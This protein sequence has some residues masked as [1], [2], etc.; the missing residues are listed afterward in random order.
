MNIAKSTGKP[1]A[2]LERYFQAGARVLKIHPA[3]DG[4][5]PSSKR[6][7]TLL[8]SAE[9]LKLPVIIHT[10]CLHSRLLYKNASFG[11][12]ELFKPW[13]KDFP[14]IQFVLAHM[15]FHKPNV[16]MDLA[17]EFQ[18]VF[19][20]T[21]WQPAETIGEAV[22]RIGAERV[23]FGSDWPLLGNNLSVGLQRIE[24]CLRTGLV[25]RAD[26]ELIRGKNALRLLAHVQ[27]TRSDD[28]L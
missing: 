13:F 27:N 9:N 2:E 14:N 25:T 22:R 21:S 3:A 12:A 20:D 26:A 19:V 10:G 18:N 23:L 17:C 11:N 4:E 28:G 7:R 6:Y 15:N 8:A 5:G 16:A 24:D 1:A